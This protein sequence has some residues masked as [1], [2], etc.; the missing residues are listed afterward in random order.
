MLPHNSYI[1]ALKPNV[2]IFGDRDF[3]EI[4]K[5]DMR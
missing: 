5:V 3:K 2:T 4:V 1:E